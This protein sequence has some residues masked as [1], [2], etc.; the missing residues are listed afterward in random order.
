VAQTDKRVCILTGATGR[1]GKV[2]CAR[3]AEKYEIVAVYRNAPP[4]VP[5]QDFRI[6]DPLQPHATTTDTV[7]AVRADLETDADIDRV[8]D[9]T[10]ARFD[11]I[12][13]IVNA[14]AQ[15]PH[16]EIA[17]RA[18]FFSG[19]DTHMRFAVRIPLM[20]AVS[21]AERFWRDRCAENLAQRRHVLNI[22]STAGLTI[23]PNQRHC[24]YGA[25]KA[26]MNFATAH[27]A[28]EFRTLGVRANALAPDHFP[29]NKLSTEAVVDA[30]VQLDLSD[31][32]GKIIRLDRD[33]PIAP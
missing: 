16:F 23:Y 2:F 28:L 27:L 18:R 14:A 21:A 17:D 24:G 5:H 29:S 1:F 30:A 25:A 8:V 12:D 15:F 19:L 20:L 3:H 6:V 31:L 22:S 13:V 7:Y 4:E 10:L 9:I 32:N 33:G 11:R 26:A